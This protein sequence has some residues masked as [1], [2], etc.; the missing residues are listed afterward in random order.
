LKK[1]GKMLAGRAVL[2]GICSAVSIAWGITF[3]AAPSQKAGSPPLRVGKTGSASSGSLHAQA[4]LNGGTCAAPTVIST[5]PYNDSGNTTNGTTNLIFLSAAC[6]GGGAGTREGPERVYSFSVGTG[7][8]LTFTVTP[9]AV[10]DPALY[11]LGTCNSGSTCAAEKDTGVEGQPDTIG[12][13]TLP[14]GT[15]FFYVDSVYPADDKLGQGPYTLNVQGNLGNLAPNSSFFTLTP[16]RVLDTRDPVGPFGGPALSAGVVRTYT[17][18]EQ[19]NVPAD[20]RSLA[21]N[22]TVTQPA[23]SGHVI[24]FP[25]NTTPPNA[26]TLNYRAGQTRANN[27]IIPLGS[28]GKV[29]VVSAASTHFILD[30]NGYFK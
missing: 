19:C 20:A 30:V 23:A 27:A 25:G 18:I 12:P 9:T 8:S 24:V 7:N 1:V 28:G 3:G 6:T 4:A 21:V 16:C 29:S 22:V 10:W 14:I 11:I 15:Y 5:L 17:V 26:S 13:I 2:L